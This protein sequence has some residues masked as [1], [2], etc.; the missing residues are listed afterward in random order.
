[1]AK[2]DIGK[3]AF[4]GFRL[5]GREPL[6][7]AGWAA[8]L[9]VVVAGP[10]LGMFGYIL[11]VIPQLVA[12]REAGGEPS[13]E[14]VVGMMGGLY[15]FYPLLL[16]GS[17]LGR[18]MIAGAVLRAV[19]EPEAR[20]WA[21]FRLGLGEIMMAVTALVV[22]MILGTL[23]MVGFG[24][25][26]GIGLVA[27]QFSEIAG[28]LAGGAIAL[29]VAGVGVWLALRL[30]LA[31]VMSFAQREFRFV[32]GWRLTE[33]RTGALLGLAVLL[34]VLVIGLELL[35]G[36]LVLAIVVALAAGGLLDPATSSN[37]LNIGTPATAGLLLL[38]GIAAAVVAALFSTVFLAPWAEV[39]RQ[40]EQPAA[41]ADTGS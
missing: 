26:L 13:P 17:I 39:Y 3:A 12:A 23:M 41:V 2:I 16:V 36:L 25:S 27:W 1:M 19:L 6:A 18:V 10:L 33:G 37:L 7:F 28:V 21:Y 9:L 40:L 34:V 35:I 38:L 4:S 24:L 11:A 22:G 32:E 31:P 30:S 29:G 8:F 5:I 15:A 20:Q 14:V